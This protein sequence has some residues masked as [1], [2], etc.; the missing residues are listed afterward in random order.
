MAYCN[1]TTC[2]APE[3]LA[4]LN[5]SPY[6]AE[7]SAVVGDTRLTALT[8][9]MLQQSAQLRKIR[10]A[11]ITIEVIVVI[12]IPG[13]IDLVVRSRV[14]EAAAG[15]AFIMNIHIM[16][17]KIFLV[18]EV[19]IT[20]KTSMVLFYQMI[21]Q[22][23]LYDVVESSR[24]AVALHVREESV[25][26]SANSMFESVRLGCVG[27]ESSLGGSACRKEDTKAFSAS[28]G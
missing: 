9:D 10:S 25:F 15:S 22:L 11:A 20:W 7:K 26:H 27:L 28:L 23:N 1:K 24:C 16:L 13:S 3:A 2:A 12:M 8:F 19:F 17:Q 14:E 6:M 21:V 18:G 5:I 4:V